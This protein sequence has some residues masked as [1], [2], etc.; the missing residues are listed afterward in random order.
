MLDLALV[1][2][3]DRRIAFQPHPRKTGFRIHRAARGFRLIEHQVA[4]SRFDVIAD[5]EACRCQCLHAASAM[6]VVRDIRQPFQN[7]KQPAVFLRCPVLLRSAEHA[8]ALLLP[9]TR[10]GKGGEVGECLYG[11]AFLRLALRATVGLPRLFRCAVAACPAIHRLL[12]CPA[13]TRQTK[14]CRRRKQRTTRGIHLCVAKIAFYQCATIAALDHIDQFIRTFGVAF[15][16]KGRHVRILTTQRLDEDRAQCWTVQRTRTFGRRG[17]GLRRS[18][19]RGIWSRW[20]I[21]AVRSGGAGDRRRDLGV[22]AHRVHGCRFGIN[23]VDLLHR[24]LRL[25]DLRLH[26][27]LGGLLG[28][29]DGA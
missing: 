25:F 22:P 14:A 7:R 28:R 5:R 9:L 13:S 24:L 29:V 10:I 19:W 8:R 27:H 20:G 15:A 2:D 11:C 16:L 21:R 6:A 26:P 18:G 23:R 3:G 17:N 4:R 1:V 12:R